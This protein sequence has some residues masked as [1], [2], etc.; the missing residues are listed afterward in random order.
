MLQ[1]AVALFEMQKFSCALIGDSQ[2]G[3]TAFLSLLGGGGD[4]SATRHST[5]ILVRHL[6]LILQLTLI[7]TPGSRDP[8]SCLSLCA[9]EASLNA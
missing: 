6:S 1:E 8:P 5:P 7:D 2:V 4:T 3:K 9:R